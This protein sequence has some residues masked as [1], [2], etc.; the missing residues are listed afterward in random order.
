MCF[1]DVVLIFV[2]RPVF[3]TG[4]E[5]LQFS[6]C[7]SLVEVD[8]EHGKETSN[9]SDF[10]SCTIMFLTTKCEVCLYYDT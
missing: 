10:S 2:I 8:S 1:I 9:T 5:C 3:P 7:A 4:V 6:V